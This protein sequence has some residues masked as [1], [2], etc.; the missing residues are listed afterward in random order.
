MFD[1]LKMLH[2]FGIQDGEIFHLRQGTFVYEYSGNSLKVKNSGTDEGFG[3]RV[4]NDKKIGFS[5]ANSKSKVPDAV[6]SALSISKFSASSSFSFAQKQKYAPGSIYD[7][8]IAEADEK[9]LKE[10]VLEMEEGIKKHS[11]PV[12]MVLVSQMNETA[13]ANTDLLFA[14]ARGTSFMAYAEAKNGNGMGI[15]EHSH[16]KILEKPYELGEKAGL[17]AKEMRSPKKIASGKYPVV[18]SHET[19][20]SLFDLLL[21]SFSGELKRRK[22]SKLWDK[23]EVKMFDE[24]LTV[25]DNPFADAEGKSAFD[26]EGVA[27]RKIPLIENGIV[28]NFYYNR[29][30][31]ALAGLEKEGNCGRSGYDAPPVLG[32]SNTVVSSCSSPQSYGTESPK[33]KTQNAELEAEI[34]EQL[35]KYVYIESMHGLHTANTTTGHFGCEASIAFSHENG[36]KAPV[37]GFM[38]SE[39]VFNLFNKIEWMGKTPVQSGDFISPRIAFR[40]VSL[41]S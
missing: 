29:E 12:R 36:K 17:M 37:R 4:L 32:S 24:K 22:I 13:I 9:Q 16:Y 26:G 3:I 18:F 15:A 21:Y 28:K 14:S 31:A 10:I 20:S 35:R 25:W 11:E 27:S 34:G 6:K 33:R 38:V 8:R 1:S 19:L 30:T 7:K 40:D 23:E 2:S 5:Y 39:N 41:I